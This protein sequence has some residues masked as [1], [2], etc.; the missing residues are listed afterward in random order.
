MTDIFDRA[1][2]LEQKERDA[3]I[4]RRKDLAAAHDAPFEIEGARVCLDCFEPI[5]EQRLRAL[6]TAARCVDCQQSHERR[7]RG[8]HGL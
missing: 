1:S 3:S 6:A 7:L 4:A 2:D 5:P 8:A